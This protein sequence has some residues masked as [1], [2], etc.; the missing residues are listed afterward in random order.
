MLKGTAL[1]VLNCADWMMAM[2]GKL[3]L[4]PCP[5]SVLQVAGG[6]SAGCA[7]HLPA[8][9]AAHLPAAVAN[10]SSPHRFSH[11][12]MPVFNLF[13]N[14]AYYWCFAAYVRPHCGCPVVLRWGCWHCAQLHRA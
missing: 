6:P 2:L 1:H 14:C 3:A 12:T 8:A 7:A 4:A 11:A 9:G 13:K 5:R 10:S